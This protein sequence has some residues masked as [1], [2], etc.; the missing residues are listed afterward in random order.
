MNEPRIRSVLERSAHNPG[1]VP[2][3]ASLYTSRMASAPDDIDRFAD[4]A[5]D[6]NRRRELVD[7]IRNIED[8]RSPQSLQIKFSFSV[9]SRA[10]LDAVAALEL[11]IVSAGSGAAYWEMLL[12]REGMDVLCFDS[13]VLY[14]EAMRYTEVET[15][16]ASLLAEER[17][18]ERGSVRNTPCRQSGTPTKA[19]T[20]PSGARLPAL[21]LAWPD[22]TDDSTFGY[23]CISCFRGPAVIHVRYRSPSSRRFRPVQIVW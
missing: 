19:L 4:E 7:W 6:D 11:P 21:F 22:D 16:A 17:C 2:L 13:N 23:D 14:P 18:T 5:L 9:P 1:E 10:A 15:G 3:L 12:R 20:R 8:P